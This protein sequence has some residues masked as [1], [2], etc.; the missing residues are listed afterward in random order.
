LGVAAKRNFP[1]TS[2]EKGTPTSF[3]TFFIQC[4]RKPPKCS[5]VFT[6]KRTICA[7]ASESLRRSGWCLEFL[8]LGYS[9]NDRVTGPVL[10]ASIKSVKQL[11]GDVA[12]IRQEVY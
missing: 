7:F 3:F 2:D 6:H 10:V 8:E 5:S 11:S 12:A 9:V 4:L 1:A